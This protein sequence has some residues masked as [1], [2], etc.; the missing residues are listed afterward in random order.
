M[1]T[2]GSLSTPIG[3]PFCTLPPKRPQMI[4]R[5]PTTAAQR[6]SGNDTAAASAALQ[7]GPSQRGAAVSPGG[8]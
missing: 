4:T 5:L 3:S 2:A 8:T 1:E 7:H 6:H